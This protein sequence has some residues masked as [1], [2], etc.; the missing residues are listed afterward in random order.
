MNKVPNIIS[1]YDYFIEDFL[2]TLSRLPLEYQ[3]K[4]LFGRKILVLDFCGMIS[5]YKNK[6]KDADVYLAQK[7]DAYRSGLAKMVQSYD[8]VYVLK[9][10]LQ[11]VFLPFPTIEV[12]FLKG[13]IIKTEFMYGTP[14]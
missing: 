14:R 1:I 7:S 3:F 12:S 5:K 11:E 8:I 6:F 2:E 10:E 9:Y 13:R 4:E